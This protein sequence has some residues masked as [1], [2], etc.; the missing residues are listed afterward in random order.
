MFNI[1]FLLAVAAALAVGYLCSDL[2][3]VCKKEK[4]VTVDVV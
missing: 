3:E 2:C 4:G 1:K